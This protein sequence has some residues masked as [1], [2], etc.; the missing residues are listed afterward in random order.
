MQR[1]LSRPSDGAG[2]GSAARPWRDAFVPLARVP[3]ARSSLLGPTACT[4]GPSDESQPPAHQI[5]HCADGVRHIKVRFVRLY[6]AHDCVHLIPF[7]RLGFQTWVPDLGSMSA[8]GFDR[9][10]HVAVLPAL[11]HLTH[12]AIAPRRHGGIGSANRGPCSSDRARRDARNRRLRDSRARAR[13]C[14]RGPLP[15]SY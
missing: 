13:T 10:A 7:V 8:G 5:D 9:Y 3:L 6:E 14:R 1:G 2:V 4:A 12:H 15:G 11:P